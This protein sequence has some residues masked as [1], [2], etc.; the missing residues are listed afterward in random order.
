MWHLQYADSVIALLTVLTCCDRQKGHCGVGI[1]AASGVPGEP[2]IDLIARA[3][4]PCAV[5]WIFIGTP[6]NAAAPEDAC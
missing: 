4:H 1:A 6:G 2:T 5:E 3:W